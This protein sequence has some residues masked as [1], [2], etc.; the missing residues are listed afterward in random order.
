MAKKHMLQSAGRTLFAMVL[1]SLAVAPG[2]AM[3]DAPVAAQKDETV[4]VYANP[5]GTVKSTEV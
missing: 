2:L 4:Y 1:C 3:A 5:D